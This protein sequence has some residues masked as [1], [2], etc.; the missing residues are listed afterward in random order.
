MTP[1]TTLQ[2]KESGTERRSCDCEATP[3]SHPN[4]EQTEA[5]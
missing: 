2:D 1:R 4:S 5:A 3:Q